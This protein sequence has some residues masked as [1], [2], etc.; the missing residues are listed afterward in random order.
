M[1]LLDDY[2]G[3]EFT[4][5]KLAL[6]G[7]VRGALQYHRDEDWFEVTLTAGVTYYLSASNPVAGLSFAIAFFD[8]RLGRIV[9]A[10]GADYD[11][12]LDLEFTPSVTGTYYALAADIDRYGGNQRAI[13]G[14]SLTTRATP[15]DLSNN[16]ATSG[17]LTPAASARGVFE[18]TADVD[19]FRFYAEPGYHYTFSTS[20][21]FDPVYGSGTLT[22]IAIVDQYGNSVRTP[23]AGF[24][25]LVAGDYFIAVVGDAPGAYSVSAKSVRDTIPEHADTSAQLV[26]GT[27]LSS[28]IDYE[29]D[30]DLLR[31]EMEAGKVYSIR[32]TSEQDYVW[33][34]TLMDADMTRLDSLSSFIRGGANVLLYQATRTGTYF[35]QVERGLTTRLVEEASP[36]QVTLTSSIDAIGADALGA[37]TLALGGTSAGT[38]QMVRDRDAFAIGL[39][40]GV[41]YS[42]TIAAGAGS[43]YIKLEVS[44]AQGGPVL[45]GKNVGGS[46]TVHFTP[47]VAGD[48]LVSVIAEGGVPAN[49]PYTLSAVRAGDDWSAGSAHAAPLVLGAPKAALLENSADRDWFALTAQHGATYWIEAA[50]DLA[51]LSGAIV[52]VLDPAGQEVKSWVL[53]YGIG[54]LAFTAA[55]AGVYHI[56]F[57]SSY[58]QTGAYSIKATPGQPDL[59][60]DVIGAAT[61]LSIGQRAG[62]TLEVGAD[63]DVFGLAVVQGRTYAVSLEAGYSIG[64]SM[65]DAAGRPLTGQS[66]TNA[67]GERLF[68]FSATE[69]G[70]VFASVRGNA[71][72][73]YQLQTTA[74]NDDHANNPSTSALLLSEGSSVVGALE[75]GQDRDVFRIQLDA[76][77][78]YTYQV[79][80]NSPGSAPPQVGFVLDQYLG[81]TTLE[82]SVAGGVRTVK[83]SVQVGGQYFL[84]IHSRE[85]VAMPY[86]MSAL[87]FGGDGRG[88]TLLAQTPAS[89]STGIE[90]TQR[91]LTFKFSEAIVIE[92]DKIVVLDSLGK[93]LGYAW[94]QYRYP[95][96][97]GDTLTLKLVNNLSPGS[98]TVVLPAAAIHD[99]EGN[100]YTGPETIRFSTVVPET[101]PASGNGLYLPAP[102]GV[103][104]GAGI[105]TLMVWGG[106][107]SLRLLALGTELT[108][109]DSTTGIYS[110]IRNIERL[111]FA[112]RVFALDVDGNAGQ[113]YRLYQAAFNRT[114][115][116]SGLGFW[117]GRIDAGEPLLSVAR[118]FVGS[119]EF[120][121]QYGSALTDSA[122]LEAIYQNVLHRTPDAAGLAYW[123]DAMGKGYTRENVLLF[124]SESAENKD[125]L[126]E[127]IG[128]GFHYLSTWGG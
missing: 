83:L 78:V 63:V 94:D 11:P 12:Q 114:P 116:Q 95:L 40:A 97:E 79:Q 98:Y 123:M 3:N 103:D 55:A 126:A 2:L 84:G 41:T 68:V 39:E 37:G 33:M 115:D 122:Y 47:A 46:G 91:T 56:E 17:V 30:R 109:W 59:I 119:A 32:L 7:S 70:N 6:N 31:L 15:D 74:Y 108:L 80:S 105:D 85:G 53:H 107:S 121:K 86:T 117:I 75:Q 38:L 77:R 89:D 4:T 102:G 29:L 100:R 23:G 51:L 124:F 8:P 19:W 28:S 64:F 45:A 34:M 73:N 111:M 69:S 54:P 26:Q 118:S 127:I 5:G 60:G 125:A 14:L 87:P 110:E 92:R 21:A 113:A 24:N 9:E 22:D 67:Q 13:Y 120:I 42:F 43:D 50:A 72:G 81:S 20:S 44:A 10:I 66:G 76:N 112:D 99:L 90:L 18:Q 82:E 27:E 62:G 101:L 48:Y 52:R 49:L 106:P 25:P 57:S 1:N 88:P 128:G 104:G 93:P 16:A 36:Y 61:P 35:V 58:G 65:S 71:P 96:V